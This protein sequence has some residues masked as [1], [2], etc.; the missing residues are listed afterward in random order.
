MLVRPAN[1]IITS[2]PNVSWFFW[3]PSPSPS[4]AATITVM[5]MIP[6]AMPNIVSIVRRF[7]AHSVTS[8]SRSKSR[9]DTICPRILLENDLLLLV[10]PGKN[11]SLHAVRNSQLHIHLFLPVRAFSVRDLHLRLAIFV[12]NHRGFRCHQY[13]LL[14]F[15]QNLRVGAHV[16]FQLAAEV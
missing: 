15:K 3:M 2:L 4:P 13:V 9:K 10:Q 7:C 14:F 6:H 11:F 8:V 12:V 5:E 16:R 1:T